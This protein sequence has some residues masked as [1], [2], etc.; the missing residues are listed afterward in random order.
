MARLAR[1]YISQEKFDKASEIAGS[2]FQ[3]IDL[4]KEINADLQSHKRN[5]DLANQIYRKLIAQTKN[6]VSHPRHLY[7]KKI[8]CITEQFK[9]KITI[10]TK[11]LIIILLY[12]AL[13]GCSYFG[14]T[15][16]IS[17]RS[18][19]T[20]KL[21]KDGTTIDPRDNPTVKKKRRLKN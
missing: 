1:L 15:T 16:K 11:P 9:M 8:I 6:P 3:D 10:M 5:M 14:Q 21:S 13:I 4:F 18:I 2:E 17:G 20:Q 7:L 19:P 12:C